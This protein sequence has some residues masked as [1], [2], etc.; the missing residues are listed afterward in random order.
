MNDGHRMALK[1][2]PVLAER[3][4]M[5]KTRP[6]I[7]AAM[8]GIVLGCCGA[9]QAQ[10]PYSRADLLNYLKSVGGSGRI[11]SGQH[12]RAGDEASYKHF[13]H[14]IREVHEKTDPK[15]WVG[16]YS[17][18]LGIF[19]GGVKDHA[20]PW[21]KYEQLRDDL[22]DWARAGG[23][24]ELVNHQESPE[25]GDSQGK[26]SSLNVLLDRELNPKVYERF[27]NRMSDDGDYLQLLKEAGV[28]VL[29]RPLHEMNGNWFWWGDRGQADWAKHYQALWIRM[30]DYFT[31]ERQLDNLI[32][33]Y[34]PDGQ[35]RSDQVLKSWPGDAYVDVVGIDFY[36]K[37]SIPD[38]RD[39]ALIA[40]NL[41]KT[42]NKPMAITE[43]GPFAWG[44]PEQK[45]IG[46][47]DY[48]KDLLE[49]VLKHMPEAVYFIPWYDPWIPTRNPNF[50]ALYQDPRVLNRSDLKIGR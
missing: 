8:A 36:N 6:V 7:W 17:T 14:S 29:W 26:L 48:V 45:Q 1:A 37:F 21:F 38:K 35:S 13:P 32:W 5:Q 15:T 23:I 46:Q 34:S 2:A 49:P 4:Q 12:T 9:T 33:V 24:V 3:L 19:V 20:P 40:W 18:D 41:L 27:W 16:I 28:P 42:K 39:Q 10:S 44:S 22:R 50:N 43:V 31:K 25:S 11:I 30:H 47:Y